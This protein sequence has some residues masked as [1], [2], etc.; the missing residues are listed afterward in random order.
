MF[1]EAIAT[2]RVTKITLRRKLYPRQRHIVFQ[3]AFYDVPVGASGK[4]HYGI[5]SIAA[6]QDLH[7]ESLTPTRQ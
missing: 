3:I 1:L 6:R 7:N 2:V 4:I 5:M